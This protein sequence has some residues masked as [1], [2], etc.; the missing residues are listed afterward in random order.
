MPMINPETLGRPIVTAL[1]Y[2]R[3]FF[4]ILRHCLAS[5]RVLR[6]PPVRDILQRQIYFTGIQALGSISLIALITGIVITMQ[7]TLLVGANSSVI[8]RVLLWT[9]VLELG[10]LLSAIV[11]IALSGTA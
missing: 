3:G 5:L 7:V 8:A 10:P 4:A 11:V 1:L 2:W 9:L 6:L